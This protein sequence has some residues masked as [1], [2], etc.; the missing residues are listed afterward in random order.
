MNII[1]KSIKVDGFL[2]PPVSKTKG[3]VA[4]ETVERSYKYVPC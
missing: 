3:T 1:Q 4:R 2:H